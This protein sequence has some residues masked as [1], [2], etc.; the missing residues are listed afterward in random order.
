MISF[1]WSIVTAL[2][3]MITGILF[4]E[5]YHET[6]TFLGVVIYVWT[7]FPQMASWC[8]K[9]PSKIFGK[10]KPTPVKN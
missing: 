5:G 3:F 10:K 1:V 6:G 7:I 4:W 8:V 9:A 2:G